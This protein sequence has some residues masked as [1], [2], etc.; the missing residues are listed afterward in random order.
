MKKFLIPCIFIALVLVFTLSFIEIENLDDSKGTES[1][2]Y[3]VNTIPNELKD[4]S[5]LTV[6]EED[7]ICATSKGLVEKDSEGKIIPSLATEVN[8]KED[9]IEY[10][11]K[12]REDAYWSD[13]NRI[14]AEDIA[15]FFK[16]LLKEEKDENIE[17]FLDVYGAREFR[18]GNVT[19]E[20][21]VAINSKEEVLTIRLNKKNDK[22]LEELTK[23]QYRVRKYLMMWDDIENNYKTIV[24]SGEYYISKVTDEGI[25][26]KK[27]NNNS[28]DIAVETINIVEDDNEEL[29]MAA[30]EI[31]QRDV[32]VNPPSTQLNRLQSEGRLKTFPSDNGKYISLNSED[33]KLPLSVRKTLYFNINLAM[34]SYQE[35]NSN[36]LELAESS[37]F[38]DDKENLDKLQSRKV[39][40]TQQSGKIPEVITIMAKDNN[41][42]RAILK[43]IQSWFKDNTESTVRYTLVTEEEFK[44]LELRNR[45]D[46]VIIDETA[47]SNNKEEFYLKLKSYYTEKELSMYEEIIKT[48]NK[49]FNRLEDTLFNGYSILPLLFEKKNVAVSKDVKNIEFDWYGNINFKTLK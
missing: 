48:T 46:A 15:N 5:K 20:N 24:Y 49:N 43:H 23:T 6:R 35:E 8:I 4:V 33:E 27:N 7:I 32:V 38:R 9:G 10:E 14:T 21:G 26:L 13:G 30:F 29:S 44:K 18:K 11:F 40:T 37:Y 19:F 39:M 42:N 3:A 1:L 47:N 25:E 28:K 31:G 41:E 34:T 36:Y 16:E 22:F 2:L 17:P 45:Y 12:I